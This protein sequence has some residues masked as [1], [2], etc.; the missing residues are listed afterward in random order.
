MLVEG[1]PAQVKLIAVSKYQP[2]EALLQ[3]YATGQRRFG[4]SHAQELV[5]KYQAL[6]KDIEWHFIGHLQTNKVKMIA[7]FVAMI[8]SVDTPHLLAEIDK[9]AARCERVIPCLLQVHVAREETKFGFAPEELLQWF[10]N[11]EDDPVKR[12]AHIRF[13]GI[14]CM[15]SNVDDETRIRADFRLAHSILER[16]QQERPELTDFKECS[17]GMSGDWQ[18]AVEEHSTMVRIGSA[19]FGVRG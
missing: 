9:Q 12:F 3:V 19:I 11:K 4:E 1:L 18:L 5:E 15:A 13:C 17:M 6:P 7:P 8:Q 14:M 10:L 2:Q 16:I